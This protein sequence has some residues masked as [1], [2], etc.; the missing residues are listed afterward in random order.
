MIRGVF[1]TD[2]K[3]WKNTN[4]PVSSKF[5]SKVK[6]AQKML[7]LPSTQTANRLNSYSPDAFEKAMGQQQKLWHEET[8]KKII[9]AKGHFRHRKQT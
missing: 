5:R 2:Y 7:T 9:G 1:P 3:K 4:L 6:N 8:K